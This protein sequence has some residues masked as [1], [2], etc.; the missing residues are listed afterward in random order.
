M[1]P[2]ACG[3]GRGRTPL[4]TTGAVWVSYELQATSYMPGEPQASAKKKKGPGFPGPTKSLARR[5]DVYQVTPKP[6][7]HRV[8]AP[9][10]ASRSTEMPVENTK[11][12]VTL[13]DT[14]A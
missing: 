6:I 5:L 13:T 3:E 4:R 11:L 9:P 8:N 7:V 10:T 1:W 14:S 12:F 2:V